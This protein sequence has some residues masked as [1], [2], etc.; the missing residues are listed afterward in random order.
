MRAILCSHSPAPHCL[1]GAPKTFLHRRRPPATGAQQLALLG[2]T[3]T[4]LAGLVAP[5]NGGERA[6]ESAVV[7]RGMQL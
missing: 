1:P 4:G 3:A 5:S 2:C 7:Q 6:R